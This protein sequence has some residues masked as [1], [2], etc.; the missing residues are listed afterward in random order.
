MMMMLHLMMLHLM[1]PLEPAEPPL[2]FIDSSMHDPTN[3]HHFSRRDASPLGNKTV[4]YPTYNTVTYPT[5]NTV[6]FLYTASD[7]I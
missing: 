5:Y 7:D 6:R 2:T 1:M 3:R 4:T